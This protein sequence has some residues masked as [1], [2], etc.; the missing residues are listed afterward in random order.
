MSSDGPSSARP[1]TGIEDHLAAVFARMSGL[2]LSSATVDAALELI[3]SLAVEAVPGTAGAG[4]SL[5]DA[6]GERLTA[7]ATDD[8]VRRADAIQYRLGA[9]P[10]LTAW[11]DRVVVRVDDLA[12]E[13][14]WSPW[15]R[16]AAD[17]GLGSALSAP[18]VAGG[19]A[20]GALKVCAV[21]PQAYG[22][23]EEHLMTMFAAQ[24]AVLLANVRTARDAERASAL[25]AD[26]L[27]GREVLA[28][29]RGIVMGRDGVDERTAF[30][31]LAGTAKQRGTTLRETAERL[32]RSTPR[33]LR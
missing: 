2:L 7:A 6:E 1:S 3:T 18:V 20:L 8:V 22:E 9:G 15:P 26:G 19:T 29:A 11:A 14:R 30:L 10:C 4:I 28:V 33:R 25:V 27:R 13:D 24:A 21:R 31:T 23:R 16:Q 32:A 5:L 12:R 17:L